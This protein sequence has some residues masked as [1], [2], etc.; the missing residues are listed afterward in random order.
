MENDLA[1][2]RVGDHIQI[3]NGHVFQYVVAAGEHYDS[4]GNPEQ[5]G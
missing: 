2:L 3:D 4:G 5:S 1:G